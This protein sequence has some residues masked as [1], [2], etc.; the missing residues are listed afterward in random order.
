MDFNF[1]DP[2]LYRLYSLAGIRTETTCVPTSLLPT[3]LMFIGEDQDIV[4]QLVENILVGGC[5]CVW[6]RLWGEYEPVN[7]Y[8]VRIRT[9]YQPEITVDDEALKWWELTITY[10]RTKKDA[11]HR[12]TELYQDS[13]EVDPLNQSELL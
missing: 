12:N 8:S 4:V 3:V 1:R 10:K 13:K 11:S 2:D 5:G 6:G 7:I 9:F